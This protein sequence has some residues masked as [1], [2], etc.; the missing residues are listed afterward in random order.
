MHNKLKFQL[1]V[2]FVILLSSCSKEPDIRSLYWGDDLKE[3]I[4]KEGNLIKLPDKSLK[5]NGCN[6]PIQLFGL[7][8][9]AIYSSYYKEEEMFDLKSG[10]RFLFANEKLVQVTYCIGERLITD[11]NHFSKYEKY[12]EDVMELLTQK[13]GSPDKDEREDLNQYKFENHRTEVYLTGGGIN[14]YAKN[15]KDIVSNSSPSIF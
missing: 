1:I 7:K 9:K 14:F 4:K 3:V 5:W 12:E 2:V 15:R 8:E 10:I 11:K 13:Y 6:M